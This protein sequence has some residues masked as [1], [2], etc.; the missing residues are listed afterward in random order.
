MRTS[1]RS[2]TLPPA[3]AVRIRAPSLVLVR[4]WLPVFSLVSPAS[5]SRKCWRARPHR[6]GCAM[7]SWACLARF[8]R[9]LAPT[10]KRAPNYR[11]KAFSLAIT[12]SSG[13]LLPIRR[14][15]GSWLRWSSS[16]LTIFWRVWNIATR[17]ELYLLIIQVLPHHS[18]SFSRRSCPCFSSTTASRSCSHLE[19]RWSLA[20]FSSTRF[21]RSRR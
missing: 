8:L 5:T 7:F 2:K 10:W 3:R 13:P 17:S 18:P 11:R 12:N 14:V 20:P 19:V 4:S 6:F 9:W 15:V 21:Q 1:L 16:T